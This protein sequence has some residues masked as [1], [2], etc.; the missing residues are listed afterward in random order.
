MVL[1]CGSRILPYGP[2][3]S[4]SRKSERHLPMHASACI[5]KCTSMAF[6]TDC[7][8]SFSRPNAAIRKLKWPVLE[9]YLTLIK[10]DQRTGTLILCARLA[11]DLDRR[12]SIMVCFAHRDCA[13]S[14]RLFARQG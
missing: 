11:L 2:T 5:T 7:A 14:V 8:F 3:L 9:T 13:S 6:R 12:D 4:D 10:L 1:R